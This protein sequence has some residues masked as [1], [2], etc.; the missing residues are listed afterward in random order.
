MW[1]FII[2]EKTK[3]R[4]FKIHVHEKCQ[5]CAFERGER[6]RK[7]KLLLLL[8]LGAWFIVQ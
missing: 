2:T 3:T 4:F 7:R 8:D 1:K 5:M 6:Y